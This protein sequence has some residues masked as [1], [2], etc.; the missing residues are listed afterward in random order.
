[1]HVLMNTWITRSEPSCNLPLALRCR[2]VPNAVPPRDGHVSP[3]T[4]THTHTMSTSP[5]PTVAL[6]GDAASYS[7]SCSAEARA[8]KVMEMANATNR[9]LT[10]LHS[11][12]PSPESSPQPLRLDSADSAQ[13]HWRHA[14]MA[15]HMVVGLPLAVGVPVHPDDRDDD[16]VVA[17][18]TPI[19]TPATPP[20][21][22]VDWEQGGARAAVASAEQ[23]APAEPQRGL[24]F[25]AATAALAAAADTSDEQV[26]IYHALGGGFEWWYEMR[27]KRMLRRWLTVCGQPDW[28][29][30]GDDEELEEAGGQGRD[31]FEKAPQ[32]LQRVDSAQ[33]HWRQARMAMHMVVGLP[34]AVGV[35]V[36]PDDRDDDAVVAPATP[37]STPATTPFQSVDWEQTSPVDF[38]VAQEVANVSV[39]QE[40]AELRREVAEL[41][42]RVDRSTGG[43]S[44]GESSHSG[45]RAR[46]RA[47]R[48]SPAAPHWSVR[49]ARA[50]PDWLGD[51]D[52]VAQLSPRAS[53]FA[54]PPPEHPGGDSPAF[55]DREGVVTDDRPRT[56]SRPELDD[57]ESTRGAERGEVL[58]RLG[59]RSAPNLSVS[60][61][62]LPE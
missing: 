46:V 37:I 13:K 23:E 54:E 10:A 3:D 26:D 27:L 1:M 30:E 16:A 31:G 42:G 25:E 12:E 52:H 45:G 15:M 11:P 40:L 4:Q 5:E 50:R 38:S 59:H 17:P 55:S 47:G 8:L 18:A 49:A 28:H 32:Q 35:P 61:G 62:V 48:F 19:S 60:E 9:V 43:A 39:A 20:F 29:L 44:K 57:A 51:R 34:L 14:R 6:G 53:F 21:Q 36:H 56:R 22:S 24:L 58:E 7:P 41:R 33:K 2:P